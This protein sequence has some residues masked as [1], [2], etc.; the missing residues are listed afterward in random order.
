MKLNFILQLRPLC[1]RCAAYK[2]VGFGQYECQ[3]TPI[4]SYGTPNVT[5]CNVYT[6]KHKLKRVAR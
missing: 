1:Y 4:I 5:A 3:L 6:S 2:C